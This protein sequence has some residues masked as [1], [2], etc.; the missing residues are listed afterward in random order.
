[1]ALI[2]GRQESHLRIRE[3]GVLMEIEVNER[4]THRQ[5]EIERCYTSEFRW[6][7]GSC[8]AECRWLVRLKR[9]MKYN[10][11]SELIEGINPD[12]TW[13]LAHKLILNF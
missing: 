2:R 1:M 4:W 12:N 7:K 11:P 9:A 10:L 3:G 8:T 5:T 6:R 13:V